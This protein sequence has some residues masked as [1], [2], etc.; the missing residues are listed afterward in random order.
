MRG[1]GKISQLAAEHEIKTA[2]IFLGDLTGKSGSRGWSGVTGKP[3]MRE[4]DMIL[5]HKRLDNDYGLS[6]PILLLYNDVNR[7]RGR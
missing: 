7:N 4:R 1:G 3:T 6:Y 2:T 5:R